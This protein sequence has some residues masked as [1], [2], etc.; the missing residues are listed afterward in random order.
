MKKEINEKRTLIAF[1]GSTNEETYIN[2]F[3]YSIEHYDIEQIVFINL[4]ESSLS[5]EINVDDFISEKLQNKVGDLKKGEYK[6][7]NIEIS[8]N[9]LKL[10]EKLYTILSRNKSIKQVNFKLFKS[11]FYKAI[12]SIENELI[13]DVTF[14]P[15]RLGI[16][17]FI[18]L[19][20]IGY[21][22]VLIC[23]IKDMKKI[24]R[25][26]EMLY[27]II[28]DNYEGIFLSSEEHFSNS[29]NFFV[30]QQNKSKF[31][32]IFASIIISTGVLFYELM[33]GKQ[34]IFGIVM[35]FLG[36]I[37]GILPIVEFISISANRKK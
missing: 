17:V 13:F 2:S 36:L 11:D 21:R 12:K 34:F 1:I 24:D 26:L 18:K 31:Y 22:D 23:E 9:Y 29:V 6:G 5:I 7:N 8:D 37:G 35:M 33:M 28:K 19:L 4:I 32:T 30:A 25:K 16:D 20:S 3:L 10:Y 27:H 15:K 14:L